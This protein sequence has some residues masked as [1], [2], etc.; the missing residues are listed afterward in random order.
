M[1]VG[2]TTRVVGLLLRARL[3]THGA[4]RA[5]SK[6]NR[7]VPSQQPS[8]S[9]SAAA[10]RHRRTRR[11]AALRAVLTLSVTVAMMV[12]PAARRAMADGMKSVAPEAVGMSSERLNR[13]QPFMQG[14]IDDGKLAGITTLV[15]RRGQVAHFESVGMA[16]AEGELP[17]RADTIV[18]IYSMTKPITSVAVMMLY[19]QGRLR[20][21]A[22]VSEYIPEFAKLRVYDAADEA[23]VEPKRAMTVRDLL[24]HT[25]GLSY[26]WSDAPVDKEYQKADP[27]A[28][29][30]QD[31]ARKLGE[32]PLMHQP[33]AA[34]EYSQ[35][36]RSWVSVTACS[37][38]L[39]HGKNRTQ[40][41][42][43]QRV[44]AVYVELPSIGV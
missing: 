37:G 27:R 43:L 16:H 39:G 17:M 23:G 1:G 25:P 30:L 11:S 29:T 6:E 36:F 3:D 26:G 28:G 41:G 22:P 4:E 10:R 21:N 15:A 34:W 8:T 38:I 5:R 24:T 33:G 35:D 32:I 12:A 42:R 13:I 19:E 2:A 18:R 20:L 31:M 40:R 14:Y 7:M 44:P 9:V